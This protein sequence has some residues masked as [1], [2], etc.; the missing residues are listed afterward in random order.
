M[1]EKEISSP[2]VSENPSRLSEFGGRVHQLIHE[3]RGLLGIL[4]SVKGLDSQGKQSQLYR[5]TLKRFHDSCLTLAAFAEAIALLVSEEERDRM[6]GQD[7]CSWDPEKKRVL[8][9]CGL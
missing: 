8:L 9:G 6:L 4:K 7:G 1:E 3:S 2:K 5:I